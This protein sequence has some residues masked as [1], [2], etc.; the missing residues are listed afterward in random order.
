MY[1]EPSIELTDERLQK[2]LSDAAAPRLRSDE[3]RNDVSDSLL[4]DKRSD[5]S[6]QAVIL[7]CEEQQVIVAGLS[8]FEPAL[9]IA[10]G[11]FDLRDIRRSECVGIGFQGF[12][13]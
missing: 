6:D 1:D 13:A 3:H 9:P 5:H 12:E 10:V 8:L 11:V 4:D 2:E 7:T